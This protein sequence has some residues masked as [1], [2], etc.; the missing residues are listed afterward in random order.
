M[1][2]INE[3]KLAEIFTTE[4]CRQEIGVRIKKAVEECL[5]TR[6]GRSGVE[7]EVEA[8]VR[9]ETDKIINAEFRD[10][11][12]NRVKELLTPLLVDQTVQ[13]IIGKMVSNLYRD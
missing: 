9:K 11:I 12:T 13:S 7:R 10:Q 5:P 4:L 1:E 3:Q 2:G 8:H 6:Y